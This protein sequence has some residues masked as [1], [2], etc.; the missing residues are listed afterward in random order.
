[1]LESQPYVGD[2]PTSPYENVQAKTA[3]LTGEFDNKEVCVTTTALFQIFGKDFVVDAPQL[4]A[5]HSADRASYPKARERRD[6]IVYPGLSYERIQF[7]GNRRGL[8]SFTFNNRPCAESFSI[9]TT[10]IN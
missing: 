6:E 9:S 3:R 4:V 5:P 10:L 2:T 7:A 1:M 8:A